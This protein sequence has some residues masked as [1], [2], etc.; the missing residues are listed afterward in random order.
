M[1]CKHTENDKC[2][3]CG[4]MPYITPEEQEAY[5]LIK[6]LPD[7]E[8]YPIPTS[9]FKKFNIPPRNPTSVRDYLKENHAMKMANAPKQLPPLIVREPQQ[10]GKLVKMIEEEPIKVETIQRPF[11]LKEGEEFPDVL[12]FLKDYAFPS[13]TPNPPTDTHTQDDSKSEK[14]RVRACTEPSVGETSVV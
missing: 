7:F 2:T 8:N 1:G 14:E 9:W 11:V 12:P 10:N 6:D 4:K 13:P 5:D 3:F